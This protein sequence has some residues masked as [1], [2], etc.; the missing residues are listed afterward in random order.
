MGGFLPWSESIIMIT[1][2]M[3][4]C[5]GWSHSLSAAV[6]FGP[7]TLTRWDPGSPLRSNRLSP[8]NRNNFK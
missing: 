3:L 5:P 7:L 8:T 6:W 1:P 2:N 4:D